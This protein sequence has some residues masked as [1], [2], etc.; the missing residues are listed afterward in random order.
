MKQTVIGMFD[1]TTE[2]QHA[3]EKLGNSGFGIDQVDLTINSRST[4]ENTDTTSDSSFRT[5]DDSFGEKVSRFFKSLFDDDEETNKYSAVANNAAIVT[6]LAESSDDAERAAEILDECGAVDVDERY[7][8]LQGTDYSS[9]RTSSV[10]DSGVDLSTARPNLM[11]DELETTSARS[12][13]E[14]E[15]TNLRDQDINNRS[16]PIIEEELHV[17]KR[18]VEQGAVRIRSRIIERPVEESVRLRE[19]R[20]IVDRNT[21]NRPATAGDLDT[22]REGEIE[23]TERAEVPVVNKEARVVEEINLSKDIR[24]REETI[25]DTV[26]KTEVEIDDS[27]LKEKST[28]GKKNKL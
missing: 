5:D 12:T 9:Q 10:T 3:V 28:R 20:V 1:S 13:D 17:G 4:L 11:D 23:L 21:V 18:E 15:T 22:F 19:E 26:R 14:F 6:V 24:E 7:N 8:Q 27:E 16:I 2:A 25:H